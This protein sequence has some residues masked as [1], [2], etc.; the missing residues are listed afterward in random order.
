CFKRLVS[1]VQATL[2][3]GDQV[4]EV[5]VLWVCNR[6]RFGRAEC[7][8]VPSALAET[9][10]TAHVELDRRRTRVMHGARS[11]YPRLDQIRSTDKQHSSSIH[12][13]VICRKYRCAILWPRTAGCCPGPTLRRS[14]RVSKRS[15]KRRRHE[16][17]GSP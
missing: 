16:R 5:A 2:V 8:A 17:D 10:D 4:Q 12:R 15:K 7:F 3:D 13:N 14:Q 9:T 6:E 1:A 11:E